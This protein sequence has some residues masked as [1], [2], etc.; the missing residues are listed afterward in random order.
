MNNFK[1]GVD[2]NLQLRSEILD[3]ALN[4]E[5]SVNS[6]L[7]ILLSIDNPRRKAIT[8][9]S[10]NLSFKNKI[11][12]LF[13]L[14]VLNNDEHKKFLLL[15]E[16][17]NQFMHNIECNSFENAVELLGD[18]KGKKLLKFDDLDNK[19]DRE[20]RFQSAFRNLNIKNLKII[21]DKIEDRINHIKD[22]GKIRENLLDG[23]IFFVNQYF[24][25][26]IKILMLC[27]N[28]F[29][30][31]TEVIHLINQLNKTI[32][33][34][35]NLAFTSEK[36]IQIHKEFKDSSTTEKIKAYLKKR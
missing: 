21:S 16:F 6:L 1:M 22:N 34:D 29:S 2:I 28:N 25:I 3:I 36:F 26:L 24:D 12:L 15:M 35:M 23:Q 7:L 27:E 18:D 11:D 32:T 17:R 19:H 13:D 14:D 30:R 33:D 9:K 10:G 4:L 20:F 31:N 5:Q 8:N